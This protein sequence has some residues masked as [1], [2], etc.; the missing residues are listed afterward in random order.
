M[1]HCELAAVRTGHC[2]LTPGSFA[3]LRRV[4]SPDPPVGCASLRA[5]CP[6]RSRTFI[7]LSHVCSMSG[8]AAAAAAAPALVPRILSQAGLGADQT[9]VAAA[10]NAELE[11]LGNAVPLKRRA[12]LYDSPVLRITCREPFDGDWTAKRSALALH[13]AEVKRLAKEKFHTGK[14]LTR[15]GHVAD[16]KRSSRRAKRARKEK[17]PPHARTQPRASPS[18]PTDPQFPAEV[19]DARAIYERHQAGERVPAAELAPAR[20]LLAAATHVGTAVAPSANAVTALAAAAAAA[21]G[22]SVSAFVARSEGAAAE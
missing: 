3:A 1:E 9:F 14:R 8:A 4:L 19:R 7:V 6:S 16:A 22:I 18:P 10:H 20:R 2:V 21:A 13:F 5:A 15:E 17:S 12:A 11:R